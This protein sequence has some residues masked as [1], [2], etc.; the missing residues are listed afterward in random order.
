MLKIR[1]MGS[2][3]IQFAI[4][5]SNQEKWG[6]T[7]GDL[8]RILQLDPRGS[9][10]AVY[11]SS[12][13]G[14]LTTTSYGRKLAWIGNVIVDRK[15]R[16]N[17][18]GRTLVQNAIEHLRRN[19]VRH[20][21]LY[22]FDENVRFYRRLGF[23]RDAPFVR[24]HR[25]PKPYH[26]SPIQGKAAPSMAL[27]ELFSADRKAFGADRSR[28]IQMILR[29]KAGSYFGFA[30][31]SSTGSYMLVKEYRE[32]FEFGP[33]VCVRPPVGQPRQMLQLALSETAEKPI[34]VSCLRNHRKAFLLFE[35]NGF[36]TVRHGYRMYLNNI[37]RI[38]DTESNYALG[39]L[40]KG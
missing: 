38:G 31:S 9:F 39:F 22:C 26:P 16:G 23:V 5:L 24:L 35:K 7:R 2:E 8:T 1:K 20:I 11:G 15:H 18:I 13:V 33:W 27:R 29:S 28:L 10:V 34:E 40:D 21:G 30:N 12:R 6:V 25:R 37:P 14:L 17:R 4:R 32:M 3:D 36:E 19:K